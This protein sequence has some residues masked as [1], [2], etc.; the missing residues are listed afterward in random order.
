MIVY[1]FSKLQISN[2]L[3]YI[4]VKIKTIIINKEITGKIQNNKIHW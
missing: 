3:N 4:N 1:I 2:V